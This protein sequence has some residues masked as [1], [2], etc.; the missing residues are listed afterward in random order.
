MTRFTRQI[1]SSAGTVVFYSEHDDPVHWIVAGRC[2]ERFALKATA[3]GIRNTFLNQPVKEAD[4]RPLFAAAMGL[5]EWERPDFVVHFGKSPTM[6]RSYCRP[7][8]AVLQN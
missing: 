2:Y 6:P 3:L 4:L 5:H 7:T 1:R 8:E